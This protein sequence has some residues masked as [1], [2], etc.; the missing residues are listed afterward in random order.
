M[1]ISPESF[2]T[3]QLHASI[4]TAVSRSD[5]PPLK[6][7]ARPSPLAELIVCAMER[8]VLPVFYTAE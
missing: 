3:M 2:V 4:A 5:S 8:H 7:N 6:S 1:C